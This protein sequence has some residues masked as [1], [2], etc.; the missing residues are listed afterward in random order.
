MDRQ[1]RYHLI[2][3]ALLWVVSSILA[4]ALVQVAIDNWP[5]IGSK[6]AEITGEAIFFLFR[7]TAPVF[8]LVVIILLYAAIRF[9]VP[10][11]DQQSAKAQFAT[12]WLFITGWVALSL[13]LNIFFIFHPGITGLEALW[14]GTRTAT[15]ANP[16]RISVVGQQW[17]WNLNYTDYGVSTVDEL[18]VPVDRPIVFTLKTDDV[19]HSFWVPA[20]GLKKSLIPGETRTLFITPTIMSSTAKEPTLRLQCAQICGIGH[21]TM[22]GEVRVVSARDFDGWIAAK[23]AGGDGLGGMKM[24]GGNGGKMQMPKSSAGTTKMPMPQKSTD[25]N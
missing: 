18:V 16:L 10:Q 7:A 22:R 2:W 9:R 19:M 25:G 11:D 12:G 8:T 15:A 5:M 17:Q 1:T 13:I 6:E 14:A 3:I 24:P 4:E 23:K 21:P 20:W